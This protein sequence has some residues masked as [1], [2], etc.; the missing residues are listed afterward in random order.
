MSAGCL[1]MSIGTGPP[2]TLSLSAEA[3]LVKAAVLYADQITLYSLPASMLSL[4]SGDLELSTDEKI[5]LL[6]SVAP[7]IH[8]RQA[9]KKD[10]ANLRKLRS[11]LRQKHMTW[12]DRR[13]LNT[14]LAG[15]DQG[16]EAIKA[17]MGEIARSAGFE[18]L[19]PA[20]S[21]GILKLHT[22]GGASDADVAIRFITDCMAISS[23]SQRMQGD[24]KA[25]EMRTGEQIQE[26]VQC[27]LD[28]V[29][30]NATFPVFDLTTA[31]LVRAAVDE[32]RISPSGQDQR[33]S[34]HSGLATK[35]LL[36]L[37]LFDQAP[38]LDVIDIRKELERPLV[39][40]R[41]AVM[42]Y[43]ETIHGASWDE[44]FAEEAE[45]V[46]TKEVR[47]AILDLED[48]IKSNRL[49]RRILRAGIDRP[50]ALPAGSALGIAISKL[51]GVSDSLALSLS[52]AGGAAAL[53]AQA[54]SDWRAHREESE[55][56]A[57]FFYYGA[58][59]RISRE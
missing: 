31:E 4:T 46:F 48:E 16:W 54:V 1:H 25:L 23:R 58:R 12:S 10:Q 44:A 8:S 50:L 18:S 42:R 43:S 26:Y 28:A 53:I 52:L 6:S 30:D 32:S 37:P 27:V 35:L 20:M 29:S 40:F 19:D 7:Y 13:S 39:R 11:R 24:I 14:L 49:L 41:A 3:R 21:A 17:K 36:D 2:E 38:L 57:L 33:R 51:D 22:F 55:R 45:V 56:N 15:I 59:K 47:P 34:L 9:A 5:S